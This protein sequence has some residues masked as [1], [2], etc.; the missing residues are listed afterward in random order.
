MADLGYNR[1]G[2]EGN[3]ETS[4]PFKKQPTRKTFYA[5]TCF[6]YDKDE[7]EAQLNRQLVKVSKK[8]IYGRE[9]CPLT[10]KKHLQGFI[11]L[12]KP[13]RITELKLPGK[14]HLEACIGSEEQNETYCAK[15]NDVVRYGYPRPIDVI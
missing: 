10:Q 2:G 8:Y 6:N 12:K 11:H 3:T 15:D 9:I 7:L 4:P 5:F 13:M 14:P 1:Q